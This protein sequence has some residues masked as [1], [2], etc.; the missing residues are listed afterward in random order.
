MWTIHGKSSS[1]I[2]HIFHIKDSVFILSMS[3]QIHVCS[4]HAVITARTHTP[5]CSHLINAFSS[6]NMF[7]HNCYHQQEFLFAL[8]LF[9]CLLLLDYVTIIIICRTRFSNHRKD[10]ISNWNYYCNTSTQYI[11]HPPFTTTFIL[12]LT[13]WHNQLLTNNA[14]KHKLCMLSLCHYS[15]IIWTHA[16]QLNFNFTWKC[17]RCLKY[18]FA[19]FSYKKQYGKLLFLCKNTAHFSPFASKRI[20]RI[21][22][23]IHVA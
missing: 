4:R 18:I 19:T 16:R 13:R 12:V 17:A 22:N 20:T 1:N 6:W 7:Y 9:S 21:T 23:H 3:I 11:Q 8:L 5:I 14:P 15:H 10:H 2:S